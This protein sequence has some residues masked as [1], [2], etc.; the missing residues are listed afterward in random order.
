M[1]EVPQSELVRIALDRTKGH[2]FENFAIQ[3][4]SAKFGASFVPLGGIHDGGADGLI[5]TGLHE[6]SSHC[7][8]FMQATIQKDYR[9]K[10][11]HTVRRLREVG[12]SPSQLLYVTSQTISSLD[13]AEYDLGGELE[14]SIRIWDGKYIAAQ[15]TTDRA[16]AAA[17]YAHLHHNTLFLEGIGRGS[18]LSQSPH[19]SEP[20][21][22]T[23]LVGELER[24]TTG[25]SF[26]DGVVD[27]MIVHRA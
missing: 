10:I 1:Q 6:D 25:S 14:I 18:V 4:L 26:A 23:F 11:R 2:E 22:Y 13:V 19:I 27:A 8:H 3:F 20:H 24:E 17:Y 12:R 21:V 15:V 7:H 16:S 5:D 9:S